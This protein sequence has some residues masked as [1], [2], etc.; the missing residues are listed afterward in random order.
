MYNA[1]VI[2]RAVESGEVTGVAN[3]LTSEWNPLSLFSTLHFLLGNVTF[4]STLRLN[5]QYTLYNIHVVNVDHK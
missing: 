3:E 1:C 2:Y 5:L 4:A